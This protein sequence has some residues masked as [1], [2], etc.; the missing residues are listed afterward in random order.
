MVITVGP[1]LEVAL[2]AVA[3]RRGIALDALALEVLREHF[4]GSNKSLHPQDDWERQ[5]FALAK[6]CGV[7]LPNSAFQREAIYE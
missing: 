1:D 4:L 3:S 5:L 2:A 7:S 6:D